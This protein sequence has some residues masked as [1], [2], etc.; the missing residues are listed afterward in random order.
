MMNPSHLDEIEQRAAKGVAIPQDVIALLVEV[1]QLQHELANPNF[2]FGGSRINR[3]AILWRDAEID[4][5]RDQ[6]MSKDAPH[7]R[8]SPETPDA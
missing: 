1:R 6:L 4:Q 2:L 7:A 5:L 3:L 8:R